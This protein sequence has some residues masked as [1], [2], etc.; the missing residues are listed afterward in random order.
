MKNKNIFLLLLLTISTSA[1]AMDGED[2]KSDATDVG[3]LQEHKTD[4]E[5]ERERLGRV[6]SKGDQ[7]L[8]IVSGKTDEFN[9]DGTDTDQLAATATK[10]ASGIGAHSDGLNT[11][12]AKVEAEKQAE[13]ALRGG[14]G[15]YGSSDVQSDICKRNE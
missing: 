6:S 12:Q 11:E 14:S 15:G 9:R 13:L 1:W 10:G 2:A 5:K 3:D 4:E 7:P 8:T